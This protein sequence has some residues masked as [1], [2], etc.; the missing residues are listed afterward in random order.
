MKALKKLCLSP[1]LASLAVFVFIFIFLVAFILQ[2]FLDTSSGLLFSQHIYRFQH[3][4]GFRVSALS[5]TDTWQRR[6][7]GFFRRDFIGKT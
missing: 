4:A 1:R 2:L 5:L 6:S 7:A 3:D